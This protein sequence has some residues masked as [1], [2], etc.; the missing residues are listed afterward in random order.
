MKN[1]SVDQLL[2]RMPNHSVK[3]IDH[4]PNVYLNSFHGKSVLSNVILHWHNAVQATFPIILKF[5]SYWRG[6]NIL[7]TQKTHL[8]CLLYGRHYSNCFINI[9]SFNPHNNLVRYMVF[10]T[11][12]HILGHWA[13]DRLRKSQY[14][15]N[16]WTQGNLASKS[17]FSIIILYSLSYMENFY[18]EG[19]LGNFDYSKKAIFP[20][21]I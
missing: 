1:S 5:P 17:A 18:S 10:S 13:I 11:P 12:R 6:L 21:Y 20:P 9:C 2:S 7:F 4:Q 16:I 15:A 8:R 14:S 3:F 19:N